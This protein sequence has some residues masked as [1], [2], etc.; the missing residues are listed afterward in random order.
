MALGWR[1]PLPPFGHGEDVF[2][3]PAPKR[4]G[5]GLGAWTETIKDFVRLGNCFAED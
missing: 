5:K 4:R 1:Y 3:F 2:R